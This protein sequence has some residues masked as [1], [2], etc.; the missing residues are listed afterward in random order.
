MDRLRTPLEKA[1][2]EGVA[3][4]IASGNVAFEASDEIATLERRVEEALTDSLGFEV[5]AFVRT[6]AELGRVIAQNPFEG[7]D[8]AALTHVGFFKRPLPA[9][10][11]AAL[12]ALSNETDALR[13]RGKEVYWLARA[14]MGRATVSGADI[15]KITG[16]STTLRSL[17]ML[18]RLHAKVA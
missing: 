5:V 17:K 4:F 10:R 9:S 2:F 12:E 14:G 16:R 18:R 15:E 11:R 3:T 13:A 7:E 1:G 6:I 8:A